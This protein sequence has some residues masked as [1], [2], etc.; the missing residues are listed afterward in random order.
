MKKYNPEIKD[1]V[2]FTMKRGEKEIL[3][4]GYVLEVA[5]KYGRTDV[6]VRPTSVE[7]DLVLSATK[8]T[9]I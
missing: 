4:K 7:G 2:S 3:V 9:K 6:L 8:L 5:Q 1:T